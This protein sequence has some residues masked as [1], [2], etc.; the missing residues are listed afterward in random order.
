MNAIFVLFHR[1]IIL[2]NLFHRIIILLI[3][4]RR[5]WG[6]IPVPLN[7]YADGEILVGVSD[8]GSQHVG[9]SGT[10]AVSAWHHTHAPGSGIHAVTKRTIA[11]GTIAAI[12]IGTIS[13]IP[14]IYRVIII[15]HAHLTINK[16]LPM[17]VEFIPQHAIHAAIVEVVASVIDVVD[18]GAQRHPQLVVLGEGCEIGGVDGLGEAA[19][20]RGILAESGE[21]REIYRKIQTLPN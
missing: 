4:G 17:L 6:V 3:I 16:S 18:V 14:I 13:G 1:I 2:L 8:S 7:T 19:P 21:N 10:H 9:T 15:S 11:I 12:A 20:V 5:L